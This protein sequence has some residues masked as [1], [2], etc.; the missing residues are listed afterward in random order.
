MDGLHYYHNNYYIYYYNY[1]ICFSVGTGKPSPAVSN[2]NY[3]GDSEF[4]YT[5]CCE[6][7]LTNELQN[8]QLGPL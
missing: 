6:S 7:M 4:N 3:D 5:D 2:G 1:A 8:G